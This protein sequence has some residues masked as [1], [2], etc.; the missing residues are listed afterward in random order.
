M[1]LRGW[2]ATGVLA[3]GAGLAGLLYAVTQ[4]EPTDLMQAV[5]LALLSVLLIGLTMSVGAYLNHRLARP[6][7]LRRDPLRLLREGVSVALFGV[8]C[9]WLQMEGDLSL[10]IAAIIAGLLVLA[11]VFFL[12]RGKG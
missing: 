10:T 2:V 1:S 9:S 7:W 6:N 11:E 8:L 5:F 12:T 3:T 4:T